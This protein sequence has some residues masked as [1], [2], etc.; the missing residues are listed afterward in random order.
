MRLACR[1]LRG[2]KVQPVQQV[3]KVRK[4]QLGTLALLELQVPRDQLA[5]PVRKVLLAWAF[6]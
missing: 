1:A 4:V 2:R 6:R 5:Q 3:R